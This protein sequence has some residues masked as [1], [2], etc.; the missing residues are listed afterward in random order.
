MQK[1]DCR[2]IADAMADNAASLVL[3]AP[4]EQRD[5]A[6]ASCTEGFRDACIEHGISVEPGD[7]AY[8]VKIV[9]AKVAELSSGASVQSEKKKFN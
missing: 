9:T 1:P 7:L 2:S 5:G 6:I 3:L 8:Y 4:P